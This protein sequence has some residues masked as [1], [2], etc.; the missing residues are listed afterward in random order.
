[1]THLGPQLDA[2]LN[3][4]FRPRSTSQRAGEAGILYPPPLGISEKEIGRQTV[5][6]LSTG[7][8]CFMESS[9]HM[10]LYCLDGNMAVYYLHFLSFSPIYMDGSK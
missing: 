3:S 5:S 2:F 9:Q 6:I 4:K 10:H 1:M 7:L 8:K